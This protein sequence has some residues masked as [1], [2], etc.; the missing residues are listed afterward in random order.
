MEGE[1]TLVVKPL[2]RQVLI[3]ECL[4]GALSFGVFVVA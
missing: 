3:V 2:V 1:M 4:I